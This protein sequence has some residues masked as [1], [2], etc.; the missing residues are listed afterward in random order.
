MNNALIL[1]NGSLVSNLLWSSFNAA[2]IF[3]FSILISILF[4]FIV[5]SI[6]PLFNRCGR[7]FQ[8]LFLNLLILYI[9]ITLTFLFLYNSL[10]KLRLFSSAGSW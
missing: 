2:N 1:F 10:T 6:I 5:F 9:S 8:S 4:V 7:I 3:I